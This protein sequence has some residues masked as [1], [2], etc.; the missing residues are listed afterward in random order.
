MVLLLMTIITWNSEETSLCNKE[1]ITSLFNNMGLVSTQQI[2]LSID[3]L[4]P[5]TSIYLVMQFGR[6][7]HEKDTLQELKV[8]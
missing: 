3:L 2:L 7:H 6:G 5:V 8:T 4:I 1:F